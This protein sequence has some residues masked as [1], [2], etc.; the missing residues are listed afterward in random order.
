M[1]VCVWLIHTGAQRKP[2]QYCKA[3]ILQKKRIQREKKRQFMCV[4]RLYICTRASSSVIPFGEC[5]WGWDK[6]KERLC[7]WVYESISQQQSNSTL[8]PIVLSY[9]QK[10]WPLSANAGNN[11]ALDTS[12]NSNRNTTKVNSFYPEAW[13]VFFLSCRR[14]HQWLSP[15]S[16]WELHLIS[17]LS[18]E[19]LDLAT[20]NHCLDKIVSQ[21]WLF[22]IFSKYN[23]YA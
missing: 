7:L 14:K 4:R 23:W 3:V 19:A 11:H 8:P 20:F 21:W 22:C 10:L 12:R 2:T 6:A 17:S 9:S 18:E 16:P 5:P 1:C 13:G 15:W